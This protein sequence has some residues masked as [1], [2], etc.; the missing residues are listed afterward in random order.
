MTFSPAET[1]S[2]EAGARI[3]Y[4]E[5]E[6]NLRRQYVDVIIGTGAR[7][8][9][10]Y[11]FSSPQAGE[12]VP[13]RR[14]FSAAREWGW[15]GSLVATWRPTSNVDVYLKYVRGWKGPH[16]NSSVV[17]PGPD[18][19]T[20]GALPPPAAP[21]ILDSMEIGLKAQLWDGRIVW[22]SALFH[23]DYQDLQ[24]YA[25]RNSLGTLPIPELINA[26][27]ADILG[28]EMELDLRPLDGW[29]P[30]VVEGLWIRLTFAWL[31][32][33]YTDFVNTFTQ[34]NDG[35]GDVTK[36]RGVTQNYTGNRLINSP[37][38]SFIGFVA[39][40]IRTDWGVIT[41]RFD[42]SFKDKVFFSAANS[43]LV[44]A[45]PLWLANFRVTYKSPD[46]HFELAGWIENLTDQAYAQDVL[47]LAR[48][49]KALLY[50]IGDPRTYGLTLTLRY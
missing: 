26:D 37:E 18:G 7:R 44:A 16:I 42:W 45:D 21:E 32:A 48:L 11:P 15:A 9:V 5:K 13:A 25:L 20:E 29:A 43:D 47:N 8:P 2:L 34:Q 41:P 17:N 23:Y 10:V 38:F 1:F 6:L 4:E 36:K 35:D 33:T 27:D 28:V 39:L 3:N 50:A 30:S 24:T 49:R 12:V 19:S 14:A 31:D 46:D 22:S 40:P